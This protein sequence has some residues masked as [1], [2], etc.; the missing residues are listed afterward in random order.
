MEML[1]MVPK[2]CQWSSHL[3]IDQV[4]LSLMYLILMHVLGAASA[5]AAFKQVSRKVLQLE[6]ILNMA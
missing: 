2:S 4:C 3:K 5:T 6:D 1:L